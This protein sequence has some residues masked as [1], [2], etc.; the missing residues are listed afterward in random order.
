M[1][2]LFENRLKHIL[3]TGK[4]TAG[5]WAQLC[6]P[7]SAEILCRA[8]F[9][10][11]LIDMEHSPADLQTLVAQLQAMGAYGVV[12]LVRAPWNDLVWIKRIL[13]AGA[14]GVMIPSVNTRE[15]A[16]AAVQACKYPPVGLRGI[17]GSPRAAGF[18]RDTAASLKRANDEILV[19][20]QVETPQAIENLDEIGKVPGVD[21]LFIG[22]MDLSTSMGHLGNPAHPEVQAAIATVEAKAKALGMPLGTISAG[23]EQAKALYDRGY[24]LVTL[25]S[26]VILLS[27]ASADALAKFRE[28]FPAG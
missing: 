3:K 13:D 18:G 4:K 19:I 7:T 26:D 28:A 9:D 1:S 8:G 27:K 23:W 11:I 15:Q 21:A 24:Q 10:W 16:L 14:F 20:I 5:A 6:S 2:H 22:P 12:P 25:L 17:A